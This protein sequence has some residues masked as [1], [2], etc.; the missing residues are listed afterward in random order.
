MYYLKYTMEY[1]IQEKC[2]YTLI[3]RVIAIAEIKVNINPDIVTLLI[4]I[5]TITNNAYTAP[6][7]L[8]FD[9]K[10]GA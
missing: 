3:L 6:L 4:N 7:Y 5:I 8:P 9:P 2:N 1:R 10:G